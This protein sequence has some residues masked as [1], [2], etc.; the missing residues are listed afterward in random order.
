M[1]FVQSLEFVVETIGNENRTAGKK[2][3]EEK[4]IDRHTFFFKQ[5]I[6]VDK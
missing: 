1:N 4:K 5:P 3:S 2:I 6:G